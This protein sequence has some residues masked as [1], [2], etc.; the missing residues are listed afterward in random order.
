MKA[1]LSHSSI[2]KSYLIEAIPTRA[3]LARKARG[4]V[5]AGITT[6]FIAN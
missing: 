6:A 1:S 2:N 3:R 4:K 5:T